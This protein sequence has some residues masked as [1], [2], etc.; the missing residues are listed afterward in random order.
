M[1]NVEETTISVIAVNEILNA[2]VL[3]VLVV[4]GVHP[5]FAGCLPHPRDM[6]GAELGGVFFCVFFVVGKP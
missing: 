2:V 1:T 6:I 5:G 4:D 3:D